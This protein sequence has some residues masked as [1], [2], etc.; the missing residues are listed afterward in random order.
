MKN[1]SLAQPHTKTTW[2]GRGKGKGAADGKGKAGNVPLNLERNFDTMIMD[3]IGARGRGHASRAFPGPTPRDQIASDNVPVNLESNIGRGSTA[4]RGR[5]P[6]P[7][8]PVSS[9]P[10]PRVSGGEGDLSKGKGKAATG[11]S[12]QG[13]SKGGKGPLDQD[14]ALASKT[15]PQ[16]DTPI[17]EV[18]V[19]PRQAHNDFFARE[20]RTQPQR[21]REP[22]PT[23]QP[24]SWYY[25]NP[26]LIETPGYPIP[27][28]KRIEMAGAKELCI[29]APDMV[30]HTLSL[31]RLINWTVS[32]NFDF[33]G[34]DQGENEWDDIFS[35]DSKRHHAMLKVHLFFDPASKAPI[36]ERMAAGGPPATR[37]EQA[38]MFDSDEDDDEDDVDGDMIDGDDASPPLNVL[39]NDNESHEEFYMVPCSRWPMKNGKI[40]PGVAFLNSNILVLASQKPI[41]TNI[42][43]PLDMTGLQMFKLPPEKFALNRITCMQTSIERMYDLLR[44]YNV[45]ENVPRLQHVSHVADYNAEYGLLKLL[46]VACHGSESISEH[47]P[48]CERWNPKVVADALLWDFEDRM[49]ESIF[50][51][52]WKTMLHAWPSAPEYI[53]LVNIGPEESQTTPAATGA[54]D[55]LTD[56]WDSQQESQDDLDMND[57]LQPSGNLFQPMLNQV[58]RGNPQPVNPLLAL[59]DAPHTDP[60]STQPSSSAKRP[61][62]TSPRS[63]NQPILPVNSFL[64]MITFNFACIKYGLFWSKN[65]Q[66][67]PKNYQKM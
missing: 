53:K 15:Q 46:F 17:R 51:K 3:S 67:M 42:K 11:G 62:M 36:S 6:A 12:R 30:N 31:D 66:I 23:V 14:Q 26:Q 29:D 50:E 18:T 56:I 20:R 40:K 16:S 10:R 8:A 1:K 27:N 47:M 55:M 37:K 38:S 28:T 41:S 4:G 43:E 65:K 19:F 2:Q 35:H 49:Q 60:A 32:P 54:V 64:S 24:G 21:Q 57:P 9:P 22:Q 61:D 34:E 5:G 59:D 7:R 33:V 39:V 45:P 48:G 58:G 44:F 25:M 52:E 13:K 63:K